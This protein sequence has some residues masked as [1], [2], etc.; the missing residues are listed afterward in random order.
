[1]HSSIQPRI[2][3]R[4]HSEPRRLGLCDHTRQQDR[5][6]ISRAMSLLQ[7]AL[8]ARH[9]AANRVKR[10]DELVQR[11]TRSGRRQLVRARR[12]RLCRHRH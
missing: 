8:S 1:M 10:A 7:R 2:T 9:R 11:P 4:A 5:A 6:S 3:A 12:G